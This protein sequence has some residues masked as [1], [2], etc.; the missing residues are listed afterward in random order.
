MY[1][2]V[3][4]A[5]TD[6]IAYLIND[7]RIRMIVRVSYVFGMSTAH[8]FVFRPPAD[9]IERIRALAFRE[10]RPVGNMVVKLLREAIE[11]RNA[12][13]DTDQKTRHFS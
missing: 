2:V 9:L 3:C 4:V 12:A 5:N 6:I 13:I 8:P 1:P 10:E 11:A 7:K